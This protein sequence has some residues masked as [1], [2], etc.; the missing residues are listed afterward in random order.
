MMHV[1]PNSSFLTRLAYNSKTEQL[2]VQIGENRYVYNG[3]NRSK[4]YRMRKSS[5]MGSFYARLIKGRYP[6][7][8]LAP[9]I[10]RAA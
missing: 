10:N 5:S 4:F 7:N 9:E 1:I 8:K 3:V 6:V 2:M